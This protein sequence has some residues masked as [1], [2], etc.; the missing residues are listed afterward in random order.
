MSLAT[1]LFTLLYST[2]AAGVKVYPMAAPDQTQAPFITYQRISANTENVMDGS[3]V[4]LCNTRIQ[5]DVFSATYAQA[6][7]IA[8]EVD[9]VM[10]TGFAQ[11]ISVQSQD[12]YESEVDLYRVLAEYSIWHLP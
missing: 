4:H 2:T 3:N 10:C 9:V 1:K 6:I 5:L 12:I 7:S 8:S 11:I